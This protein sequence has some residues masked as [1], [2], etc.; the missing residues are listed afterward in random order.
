MTPHDLTAKKKKSASF[1]KNF[2]TTALK[3]LRISKLNETVSQF[4]LFRS[5]ADFQHLFPN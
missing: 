5:Y 2:E 4:E 1:I 3:V